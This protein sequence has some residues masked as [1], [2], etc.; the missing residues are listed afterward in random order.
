MSDTAWKSPS[1]GVTAAVQAARAL[2]AISL[3]KHSHLQRT[4]KRHSAVCDH[5]LLS[6]DLMTPK[7]KQALPAPQTPQPL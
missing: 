2:P 1:R 5:Y 4:S 7:P 6:P 3:G